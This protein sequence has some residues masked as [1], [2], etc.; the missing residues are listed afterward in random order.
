MGPEDLTGAGNYWLDILPSDVDSF[1][2]T[3]A[4]RLWFLDSMSRGCAGISG[5]YSLPLHCEVCSAFKVVCVA[6]SI[7]GTLPGCS[8]ASAGHV[9]GEQ[10]ECQD[11]CCRG[12]V[13]PDV[14]NWVQRQAKSLPRVPVSAAF[15][16]IPVPEF[17][18]AW[19]SG[20]SVGMKAEAVCCPSC[21]S[22][23]YRAL[24]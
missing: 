24:V 7:V 11:S 15:V 19:N 23:V 20:S 5:W 2:H 16:H 9:V 8:D 10:E 13:A 14:V 22:G 21:N 1:S 18:R 17:L 12:C 6:E 4:A 3:P